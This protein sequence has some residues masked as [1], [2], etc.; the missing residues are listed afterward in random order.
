[1]I[2][3]QFKCFLLCFVLIFLVKWYTASMVAVS[4]PMDQECWHVYFNKFVKPRIVP[5]GTM[6]NAEV[7]E[8]SPKKCSIQFHGPILWCILIQK[9]WMKHLKSHEI[10]HSFTCGM[11]AAKTFGIQLAP[12]M[13]IMYWP[14]KIVHEFTVAALIFRWTNLYQKEKTF[15][16]QLF[17]L[18]FR[19]LYN[20]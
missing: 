20:V 10:Q 14:K 4:L 13:Y 18:I 16:L 2:K 12:K 8:F 7:F 15:S 19:R 6:N 5:Y 17:F 11:I 3:L 9:N 1:M